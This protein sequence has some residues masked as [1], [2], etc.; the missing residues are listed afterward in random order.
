MTR[1]NVLSLFIFLLLLFFFRR[2]SLA[3]TGVIL[4]KEY[5]ESMDVRGLWLSEKLDGIRAVWD[6]TNLTSRRGTPIH[7][8]TWFLETLPPF[9]I[10]GELWTGRGS[11]ERVASI[12]LDKIP[13]KEWQSVELHIFEAQDESLSFQARLAKVRKWLEEY[14][15]PHLHLIPQIPCESKEHLNRFLEEIQSQGG[16]G[17]ILR[18][19][20]SL[21][22]KGRS[23]SYLKLKTVSD[24]EGTVI[25][26]RKGKG[27][28][29]GKIGA[30]KL[31]L[32]DGTVLYVG[33]GLSDAMRAHPPAIGSVITFKYR[34]YTKNGKPR[35][36]S[37]WRVRKD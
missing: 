2:R 10:E 5:R 32:A 24:A 11:F 23:E 7:A 18:D 15:Q 19:P 4:A 34:G 14:P 20:K 1:R 29:T 25:G 28:Y 6:G 22:E 3:A 31:Q 26:Y 37:F 16:E 35:F 27:K 36:A 33:S 9:P 17:V 21:Y 30:L 8:P 13:G 12:V